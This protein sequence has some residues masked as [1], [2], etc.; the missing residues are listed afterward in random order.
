M[1]ENLDAQGFAQEIARNGSCGHTGRRLTRRGAL[2]DGARFPVAILHH[3]GKVSVPGARPSQGGTA[4]GVHR[5]NSVLIVHI[6]RI[7]RHDGG[8]LGPLRIA[9]QD[10]DGT[11]QGEPM[12]DSTQHGDLISLKLHTGTAAIT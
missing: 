2:Q 1:G 3:S 7:G 10:G 5:F 12:A 9:N 6:Q 11:T 4:A 8:P